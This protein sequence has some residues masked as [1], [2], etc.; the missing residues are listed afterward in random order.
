MHT[1]SSDV[2]LGFGDLSRVISLMWLVHLS[3]EECPRPYAAI[4][5][6]RE[7]LGKDRNVPEGEGSCLFLFFK[8]PDRAVMGP[9]YI[10]QPLRVPESQGRRDSF[11]CSSVIEHLPGV[12]QVGGLRL[13]T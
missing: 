10:Q 4:L 7:V 9:C 1:T 12:R 3:T 6:S 2:Y 11:G 5:Y 8:C 13:P